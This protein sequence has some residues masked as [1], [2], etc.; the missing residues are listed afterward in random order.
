MDTKKGKSMPHDSSVKNDVKTV[1]PASMP[2]ASPQANVVSKGSRWYIAFIA[3]AIIAI[4][5][6]VFSFGQGLFRFRGQDQLGSIERLGQ[7]VQDLF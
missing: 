7:K 5:V 2:V 1:V 6:V 3:I 4:A